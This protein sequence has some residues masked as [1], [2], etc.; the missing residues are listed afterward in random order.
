MM[1]ALVDE[2]DLV[3]YHETMIGLFCALDFGLE[4]P[5]WK[6]LMCV[7]EKMLWLWLLSTVSGAVVAFG[8]ASFEKGV[9]DAS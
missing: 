6:R 7:G 3:F 8:D 2:R 4:A 9:V 1:G 5:W